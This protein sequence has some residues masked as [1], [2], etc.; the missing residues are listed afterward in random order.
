MKNRF[1][2]FSLVLS[3]ALAGAAAAAVL[4]PEKAL[5]KDTLFVVTAP[6]APRL[7]ELLTNSTMGQFWRD[8]AMKPF[9]DKFM[10]KFN[11][12]SAPILE[13]N[14]GL[15]LDDLVSL[16]RGQATLAAVPTEQGDKPDAHVAQVWLIDAKDHADQLK[17]T[18]SGVRKKWADAGKSMKVD[19]IREY[20]FTTF[21]IEPEAPDAAKTKTGDAT[22]TDQPVDGAVKTTPKKFEV[23]FGQVDSLFIAGNS[24]KAIEK[25]L[26]RLNGGMAP[27]LEEQPAFQTDFNARLKSAPMYAW[28]N[29]KAAMDLFTKSDNYNDLAAP[30]SM[31]LPTILSASGLSDITSASLTYRSGP[32]GMTGQLFVSVPE[33]N[34]RGLIKAFATDAKDAAPPAFVPADAVKFWRWRA[35]LRTTWE[36]LE[37]MLTDI[38]PNAA[39]V[40]NFIFSSA[41]KD[42]DDKYDLKA[43]LLSNLGN[44]VIT[45]GK[46]PRGDTLADFKNAPS[47]A[48]IGSPNPDA[49]AAAI[50]VAVGVLA[51]ATGGVK[52]QEFLGRKIYSLSLPGAKGAVTP[53]SFAASGG[54]VAFSAQNDM[55]EE[56]LRSNDGSGKPLSDTPGLS[57]AAQKVGGTALGFFEY[58]NY[59]DTLKKAFTLLHAESLNFS[60]VMGTPSVPGGPNPAD[61]MAKMKE[62]TDF[63]LLPPFEAVSKYF[64]F[65]VQAIHF[66]PEGLSWTFFSP[67]PPRTK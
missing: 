50:K 18:L 33:G 35:N 61:Q 59:A 62:W 67:T 66:T 48:L 43:E 14:L 44:D 41:G 39:G 2:L 46:A 30:G 36:T 57:D 49:L 13:K 3:L 7:L 40:M 28:I 4:P 45:Y 15:K 16:A 42:K 56:F 19:K 34:R 9:H 17:K 10:G 55:V 8:P 29:A 51:Q 65:T 26:G 23:V 47:V 1:P 22:D 64:Y 37:K 54:Y 38:N 21:T 58:D 27:P 32:E 20:E 25:I 60:D 12:D 11:T 63:T 24:A 5:P 6:D 53:M 31:S 52:E